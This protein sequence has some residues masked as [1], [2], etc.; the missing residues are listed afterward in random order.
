MRTRSPHVCAKMIYAMIVALIRE[1]SAN[2]GGSALFAPC[3][4]PHDGVRMSPTTF[5]TDDVH[6]NDVN[7]HVTR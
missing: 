4:P 7:I 2:D 6:R 3:E 1:G 5:S